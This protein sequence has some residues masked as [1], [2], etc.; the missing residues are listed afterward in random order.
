MAI[1]AMVNNNDVLD[2]TLHRYQLEAYNSTK[3]IT[4]LVS[5]IQGGKT[6]IGGLWMCKQI[7]L[8]DGPDQTFIIA[9]P[10]FKLMAKSTMPW[11]L[12]IL[13]GCGHFD[14]KFNRFILNGGGIV[15]FA[16]MLDSDSCEGATN[17]R[18][19]WIDEAGKLRYDAWINLLAR[20]SFLQAQIFLTTTPYAL[21]WLYNDIYMP[22]KRGETR[23][24]VHVVQFRSVDNPHFPREEYERQRKMLDPRVFKRKYGGTFQKM[25]GL[26]YPDIDSDNFC[27]PFEVG[28]DYT[29]VAGVDFGW[30]NPFA[31]VVRA[32][33][34][35]GLYDYQIAEFKKSYV[36][37][38]DRVEILRQLQRAFR[39]KRFF[40][41]SEDPG[42]IAMYCNAGLPAVAVEKGPGSV[43]L[44]IILHNELIKSKRYKMFSGRCKHTSDEYETY[45]YPEDTGKERNPAEKPVQINDHLMDGNRYV[46]IS[47]QDIR[48]SGNQASEYKK[49]K[50]PFEELVE[51]KE[52]NTQDWYEENKDMI[53]I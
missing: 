1:P 9:A 36:E 52:V 4:A 17:V 22:W 32:I 49:W 38:K 10:T 12:S 15:W 23:D 21:N 51:K 42:Q 46:T 2:I 30:T 45:H 27:P 43:A 40:C 31:I 25:S 39:I 35:D 24:E 29:V 19:I 6:R 41:D 26:V 11:A 44:G 20:S 14:A 53:I 7:A 16:S 28:D 8:Y 33:R 5:G 18:G 3:R 48:M 34:N 50:S 47:T 13:R 37:L